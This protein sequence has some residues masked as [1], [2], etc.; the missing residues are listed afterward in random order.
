[1]IKIKYDFKFQKILNIINVL[2]R[3]IRRKK[4]LQLVTGVKGRF[5]FLVF[6]NS[7]N[8]SQTHECKMR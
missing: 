7:V 4:S 6:K 3:F 8:F 1:M 5:P 2:N